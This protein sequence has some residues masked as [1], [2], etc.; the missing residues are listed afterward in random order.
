VK[1]FIEESENYEFVEGESS[2][3]EVCVPARSSVTESVRVNLIKLGQINVTAE[4]TSV[5]SLSS[6]SCGSGSFVSKSDRLIK[7]L[8]VEAEGYLRERVFTEYICS[9]DIEDTTSPVATWSISVP[10]DAVEDSGRAWITA[11]GDLLGPTIE[12]LGELVR[13]PYGCGEQNMINFAPIIYILQYLESS[14]QNTPELKEKLTGF[15]NEGYQRQLKFKR[16]D[17]SYSTF[18][19]SDEDGSTWLTAFVVKSFTQALPY[20]FIDEESLQESRDW[21]LDLQGGFSGSEG[22]KGLLAAYVLASLLEGGS[23][24]NETEGSNR[25][26][27]VTQMALQCIATDNSTHPYSLALKSYS[28][29]LAKAPN[30]KAVIDQ[31]LDLSVSNSSMLR[32]NLPDRQGQSTPLHVETAAYALLSILTFDYE[33]YQEEAKKIDTVVALQALS[34]FEGK[35]PEGDLNMNV[36]VSASDFSTAFT[37]TEINKFLQQREDLPS[38]PAEVFISASGI[39]CALV[40]GLLRYNVLT[41]SMSDVFSLNV[42]VSQVFDPQ[43]NGRARSIDICTSYQLPDERS[44]MAII[45][46]KLVTGY[47]PNE[48]NLKTIVGDS[49]G[50]FKRY[51]VDGKLVT[52][53]LEEITAEKICINFKADQIIPIDSAKPGSVSVYDFYQPEYI[54]TSISVLGH[55]VMLSLQYLI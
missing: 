11:V 20:T 49:E 23:L 32:W 37:I 27:T 9:E 31:L 50:V 51:E 6:G 33:Q 43:C 17:G 14:G 1:I 44:N 25:Q 55:N 15:L 3:R 5:P 22:S 26:S 47:V 38:L 52:L 36:V 53:Y 28:L 48:D 19:E 12:N 40:Q 18:G 29:A 42:T 45:E 54:V 2:E 46:I 39:G 4:A 34:V 24:S 30:T 13:M 35:Q 21:L 7:P 10:E 41:D 16:S 8:L